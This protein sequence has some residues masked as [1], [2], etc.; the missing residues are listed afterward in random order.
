M[1]MNMITTRP[2]NVGPKTGQAIT[3]TFWRICYVTLPR[4]SLYREIPQTKTLGTLRT[5]LPTISEDLIVWVTKKNLA[6]DSTAPSPKSRH[7]RSLDSINWQLRTLAI[8][9]LVM[10]GKAF[11]PVLAKSLQYA[12]PSIRIISVKYWAIWPRMR[13]ASH[14]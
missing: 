1:T 12:E 13:P 9:K 7:I 14:C 8:Q 5:Q 6:K 10:A 2:G 11:V 4:G 3:I